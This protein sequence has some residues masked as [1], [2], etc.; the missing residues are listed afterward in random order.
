[1]SQAFSHLVT[2]CEIR[3]SGTSQQIVSY[4]SVVVEK[5]QNDMGTGA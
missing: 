5:V 3:Y 1:M 4:Q 2:K